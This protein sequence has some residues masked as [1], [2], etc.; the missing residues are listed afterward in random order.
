MD[1]RTAGPLK[2]I[3]HYLQRYA[4][5]T[6]RISVKPNPD[7]GIIVVIPAYKEPDIFTTLLSLYQCDRP[8]ITTEVI[9]VINYPENAPKEIIS[10]SKKD[11]QELSGWAATHHD[12]RLNFHILLEGNLPK[13][14]AGPGLARK[15][16]MDEAVWRFNLIQNATGIIASLDAD[17]AVQPNYLIS[18]H[19][20]WL[21]HPDCT[22]VSI[23]FEHP[24]DGPMDERI[25][26]G[27]I[28]YEIHLRYY[29]NV[30]IYAGF[31]YAYQTVGSSFAVS[32]NTYAKQGGMNKR[33][34]G[35][36]FYF[37]QKI[38]PQGN[39]FNLNGTTVIP[40]PRPSD[41][42]PFG[43]GRIIRDFLE[44]GI[45]TITSY[46]FKSFLDLKILLD[47]WQLFC[48]NNNTENMELL[49]AFPLPVQSFLNNQNM[50][51]HLDQMKSKTTSSETFKKAF[52]QWFN[53]FMLMKYIH[54]ARDNYYPNVVIREA[55]SEYLAAIRE[56]EIS[57]KSNKDLLLWMRERDKKLFQVK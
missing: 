37:I 47:S 11:H 57:S 23:H 52:F 20:H 34:A 44:T 18:I 1:N 30:Q 24:I 43:T 22:G 13:R 15:I 31:P 3:R 10:K 51:F 7:L 4:L 56:T 36:D 41:R 19:Q 33:Q 29:I 6:N 49:K 12:E 45:G 54:F 2:I 27:I 48:Q 28:D 50:L 9:V 21:Q 40:S 26:T 38:I 14:S 35:E 39:Y 16:G 17:A 5:T 42:V 46:N 53:A 8:E 32:A 25:Y 55:V